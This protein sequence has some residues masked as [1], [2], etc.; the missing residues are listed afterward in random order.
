LADADPHWP[1]YNVGVA[2]TIVVFMLVDL[3]VVDLVEVDLEEEV[4]GDPTKS[5]VTLGG[6]RSTAQ[7]ILAS[8]VSSINASKLMS[9][10]PS[11]HPGHISMT[12]KVTLRVP[13]FLGNDFIHQDRLSTMTGRV[14]CHPVLAPRPV[15]HPGFPV[16][17]IAG[18]VPSAVVVC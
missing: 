5:Q 16:V 17:C 7:A 6:S 18:A 3:E 9:T 14:D 2:L 4:T 11:L 15:E 12:F 1:G 13:Y 8:P 10:C